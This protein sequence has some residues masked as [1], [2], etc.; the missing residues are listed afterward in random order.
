LKP[1]VNEKPTDAAQELSPSASPLFAERE[2]RSGTL[3]YRALLEAAPDAIV[4]VNQAGTIVLVNEQVGKLFGYRRGELIGQPADILV[5]EHSRVQSRAHHARFL[6]PRSER[7]GLLGQDLFGLRKDG[8]EFPVE[9]R[10]SPVDTKQGILV[11]SAIRDVS[12][13]RKTEE[14]LRRLAAIV[15]SSDDAII[16]KTLEGII[17]SWNAGAERIY[18]YPAA[19][20]IGKSIALLF[21]ADRSDEILAIL[22]RLKCGKTIRNFVTR[23]VTKDGEEIEIELT[24][25]PI[26]DAL[27]RFVG[28]SVIGRDITSY[29]KTEENLRNKIEQLKGCNE[30][31]A[32]F[33]RI[34]SDGLP[35]PLRAVTEC[36]QLLATQ[37]KGKLDSG[38]DKLIAA[39]LAG[40]QSMQRSIRNLTVLT[41][42]GATGTKL[43]DTSSE[44]ALQ[45]ALSDLAGL[46]VE[47]GALLTHDPLP[48]V[49]ADNMQL[50]QLFQNLIEHAIE[51]KGT[52]KL[53]IH[54]S[55]V[56]NDKERWMFSVRDNGT[57]I[58][59]RSFERLDR[60]QE[61]R[62]TGIDLFVCK[63]IIERHGGSMS[64]ESELGHGSNFHFE[65]VGSK[66]QF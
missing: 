65:L 13:R 34:T 26:R 2:R 15:A 1:I 39:A 33:A 44:D 24:M 23:R 55:A 45:Q 62:G 47:S 21:P 57:G 31:L 32:Q 18:G 35:E 30:E 63:K 59:P 17:T 28:A 19:E 37:Y 46:I 3:Q 22:E 64:V 5:S 6:M 11:A 14:D 54:V 42:V 61:L 52:E 8:T 38:A 41:S 12:V 60:P 4:V 20:V 25:S 29:K 58:D 56:E 10:L 66:R 40:A 36:V 53:H 49:V 27:D 43:T 16:G 9:I 50:V 48:D 7:P 51:N